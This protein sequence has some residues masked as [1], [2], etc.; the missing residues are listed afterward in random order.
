M[1]Q[2]EDTTTTIAPYLGVLLA[3][4]AI[5]AAGYHFARPKVEVAKERLATSLE[6]RKA[7]QAEAVVRRQQLQKD[8]AERR[9]KAN[10]EKLLR[11]V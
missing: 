2:K 5:G 6:V 4:I 9:R 10:R 11:A 8:I 3:G 1:A 7:L